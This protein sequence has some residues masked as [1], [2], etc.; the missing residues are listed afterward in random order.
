MPTFRL[1]IEYD[2][3]AFHGWQIQENAE[4]V[5][6][7][8]ESAVE[9]ILKKPHRAV[10]SGRTD[11]G[12]HARGQVAH[13]QCSEIPDL[14]RL[15]RSLNGILPDTIAVLTAEPAENDFHARYDARR[16]IYTYHISTQ[17]RALDRSWRVLLR[18][19]PNFDRMNE[20]AKTILGTHDFSSFCLS[21]SETENRVCTVDAAGW[22]R[23]NRPGD[24][25]FRI[26]ADRFLH[27][28]VRAIVGTLLE[29]GQ[30]KREIDSIPDILETHDRRSAGPAAAA[31]GLVLDQ[32]EY[33]FPVFRNL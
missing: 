19:A 25:T 32:V 21:R 28:M 13:V 14:G 8:L 6:G 1:L 10:G 3:S 16:R 33:P 20:A 22:T 26:A 23:E 4:S 15:V 30:G 18:P 29:I 12:V 9:T 27:G 2:G 17:A 11:T 7:H 24:F 5:Q 31:H